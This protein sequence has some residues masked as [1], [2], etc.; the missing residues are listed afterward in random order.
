MKIIL[1]DNFKSALKG[2]GKN[3]VTIDL[4]GCSE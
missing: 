4:S 2:E 3:T 1:E